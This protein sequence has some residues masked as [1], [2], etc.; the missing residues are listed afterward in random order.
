[1]SYTAPG[2]GKIKKI[3]KE[4][5]FFMTNE[6]HNFFFYNKIKNGNYLLG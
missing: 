5:F 4:L 3:I 1:M 6:K 2:V